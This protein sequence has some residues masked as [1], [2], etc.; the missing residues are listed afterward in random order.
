MSTTRADAFVLFGAS[1]DLAKKKLFPALYQLEAS[2]RLGLPVIGVAKSDWDDDGLRKYARSAVEAVHSPID[3]AAFARFA[4]H[5]SMV[6]GDYSDRATFERLAAKLTDV[7]SS[8]PAYYLAIPPSLFSTVVETL[9]ALHLCRGARVIVEKPFGRDLESARK[10]NTILHKAFPERAIFRIDH[11]LGKEPVE[12]LLV[13][14]FANSFLEPIWNRQYIS[15]VE[16]TMAEKFGVEGRGAFYDSIG[17]VRDVVQNHL[18][19]IITF[20]AMEPPV[21]DD[22]DSMRDEKVKVFKAMAAVDPAQVVRGQY[23][24]YQDEPGVAPGSTTETFIALRFAI[25]SWRW[26]GVPFFVRAGKALATTAT[27][28]TVE[29]CPPPKL[30][31]YGDQNLVPDPNLLRFR[32]GANDGVTLQVQAKAPGRRDITRAV[33]LAVDFASALGHRQEAYERLID[34]ALDGDH[35]RFSR[36]DM[37][38]EAWRIVQPILDHP[39]PVYSYPR[40]GWGPKEADRLVPRGAWYPPEPAG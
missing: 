39:G 32:L 4:A 27:E 23:E 26:A 17:T 8:R 2:G 14:R 7:S 13:F 16:I 29:L 37:V 40:G 18:L 35:R 33:E 15:H 25:D 10:L 9:A 31:F 12:D 20:L 36:E 5:I 6:G 22:A 34:D 21:R 38:E 1:G 19:Q 30:L 3:E 28:A 24:G 11:Y